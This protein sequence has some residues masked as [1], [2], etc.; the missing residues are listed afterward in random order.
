MKAFG[1]GIRHG[2]LFADL[3]LQNLMLS[4]YIAY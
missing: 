3:E 4:S 1:T 2:Q